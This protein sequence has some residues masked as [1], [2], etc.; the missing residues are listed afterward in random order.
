MPVAHG[1][2]WWP[3]AACAKAF[4]GQQD[5]PPYQELLADTLD[6]A[7][8]RAGERWLDLGCGGG[9]ISR[10]IWE[11]T[12]GEVGTVVGMDCADA[13]AAAYA[14]HRQEIACD[15]EERFA[16][17]CHDFSSGLGPL[18]D[19]TFDHVVSGLSITYAEHFDE[20]TG[21]WT[22]TAYDR[23]LAEVCR[24]IRP[25]G[26]FVFSVNV[27]DPQWGKV[28]WHSLPGLL[29]GPKKLRSLKRAWRMMRYGGWLKREAR[30]GRFHYLPADD[31]T[32]R[33]TAA[34]FAE[35][36]HRLSYRDQAFVF[37]AVKPVV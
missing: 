5:C 18:A 3:S 27:P 1:V 13:N 34:G 16:F 2:N 14:R 32:R 4:W 35:V 10:A 24:V 7:D 8:P 31:V 22:T 28:A 15:Q 11:K 6:W 36:H 20:A 17:I 25:G 29:A 33:L 30:V 26:R 12:R 21:R 19:R 23:L 37:R 9:A